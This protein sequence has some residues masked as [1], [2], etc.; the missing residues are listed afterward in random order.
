ML[1]PEVQV[2]ETL[3][4]PL[5]IEKVP[6]NGAGF[7]LEGGRRHDL[8]SLVDTHDQ[9][10]NRNKQ[11]AIRDT[12]GRVKLIPWGTLVYPIRPV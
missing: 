10:V 7:R 2:G 12:H 6:Y 1:A 9:P 11:L 8:Y 3:L 5:P 4:E